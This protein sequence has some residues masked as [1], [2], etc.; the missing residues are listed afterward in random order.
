MNALFGK[1]LCQ[2]VITS[3]LCLVFHHLLAAFIFASQN[4]LQ[5]ALADIHQVDIKYIIVTLL[6]VISTQ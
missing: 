4:F 6:D 1:R 2:L 3:V 5:G